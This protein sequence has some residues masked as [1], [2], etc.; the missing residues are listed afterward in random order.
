MID[1]I[2]K[3]L[4]QNMTTDFMIALRHFREIEDDYEIRKYV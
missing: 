2:K 1:L 4:L 3:S